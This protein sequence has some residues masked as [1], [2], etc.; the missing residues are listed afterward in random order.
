MGTSTSLTL[1]IFFFTSLRQETEGTFSQA[2]AFFPYTFLFL[3]SELLKTQK[4]FSW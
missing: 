3:N 4:L 1:H 2:V